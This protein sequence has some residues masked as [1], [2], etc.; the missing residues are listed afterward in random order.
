MGCLA[1]K[2][3]DIASKKLE[4]EDNIATFIFNYINEFTK[5]TGA[6]VSDI[7]VY[8]DAIPTPETKIGHVSVKIKLE[9]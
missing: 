8:V 4:L 7:D 3:E 6:V 9:I 5:E 2:K 1:M